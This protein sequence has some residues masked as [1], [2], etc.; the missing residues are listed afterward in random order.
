MKLDLISNF[1]TIYIKDINREQSL[2]MKIKKITLLLY[3][4]L[5]LYNPFY[6]CKSQAD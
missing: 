2:V 4:L 6:H 1:F 5:I 3:L